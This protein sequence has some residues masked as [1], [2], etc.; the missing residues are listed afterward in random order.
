MPTKVADWPGARLVVDPEQLPEGEL[1][2][3]QLGP[4][5]SEPAGAVWESVMPT[6]LKVTLPVFVATNW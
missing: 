1:S 3:V 2:E 5:V 6:E 4:L